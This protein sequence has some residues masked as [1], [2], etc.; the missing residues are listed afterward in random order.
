[1]N[2]GL[3]HLPDT[4]IKETK[5]C[6]DQNDLSTQEEKQMAT[7]PLLVCTLICSSRAVR[8]EMRCVRREFVAP[9]CPSFDMPLIW[10]ICCASSSQ[11]LRS[12][13]GWSAGTMPWSGA[14]WLNTAESHILHQAL[15]HSLRQFHNWELAFQ[16]QQNRSAVAHLA[17]VLLD[18]VKHFVEVFIQLFKL[19]HCG[20]IPPLEVY[21]NRHR[22]RLLNTQTQSKL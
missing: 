4:G 11:R 6:R 1:M 12:S 14:S 22:V 5:A 3:L 9:C 18:F 7:G 10:T 13:V 15:S 16:T 8:R 20:S 21:V 2:S 17:T 19:Q